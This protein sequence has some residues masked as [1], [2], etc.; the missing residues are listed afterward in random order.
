MTIFHFKHNYLNWRVIPCRRRM[1]CVYAAFSSFSQHFF[2][3]LDSR[4]DLVEFFK[5]MIWHDNQ[6]FFFSLFHAHN[7]STSSNNACHRWPSKLK[8]H[9]SCEDCFGFLVQSCLYH[10]CQQKGLWLKS[11]FE[12]WAI[13]DLCAQYINQGDFGVSQSWDFVL[14]IEKVWQVWNC[15]KSWCIPNYQI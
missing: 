14:L 13:F 8:H 10:Y 6:F 11:V 7:L 15:S 2:W 5:C 1:V 3:L 4:L 9:F 12:K